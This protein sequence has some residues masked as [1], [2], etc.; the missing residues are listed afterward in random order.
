[1]KHWM[2]SL[3]DVKV[4]IDIDATAR[5][6]T[7]ETEALDSVL[8][9]QVVSRLLPEHGIVAYS[10]EDA[11]WTPARPDWSL[12]IQ[13]EERLHPAHVSKLRDG[14]FALRVEAAREYPAS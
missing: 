13:W 2:C 11:G 14:T 8:L 5:V 9:L 1:M 6:V 10:D 12:R 4:A 7:L 3:P